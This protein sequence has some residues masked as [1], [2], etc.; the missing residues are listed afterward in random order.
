MGRPQ[1]SAP[2]GPLLFRE[3]EICRNGFRSPALSR[4]SLAPQANYADDGLSTPPAGAVALSASG[5]RSAAPGSPAV[6]RTGKFCKQNQADLPGPVLSAKILRWRRR[7]NQGHWLSRPFPERGV[8][9]R[10]QRGKGCGGRG[11]AVG[12]TARMRTA[13]SCGPD[14]PTLASSSR[15]ETFADDSGKKP[16][17]LGRARRKPLKPLRREGR[18]ASAEPVCSCAFLYLTLHARPRVQRAP[19]LPCAL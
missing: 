7:A 11:G 18:T 5:P 9:Q 10:H 19:G 8:G 14:A 15:K 12:R 3:P 2:L 17:S 16:R 13:K 4:H 6:A 1:P